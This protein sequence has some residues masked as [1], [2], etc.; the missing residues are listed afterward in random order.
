MSGQG[1]LGSFEMLMN[2]CYKA[3]NNEWIKVYSFSEIRKM[4]QVKVMSSIIRHSEGGSLVSS[5][6][7][8]CS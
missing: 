7:K 2:H 6:C 1:Q 8:G 5:Y 4:M 3:L